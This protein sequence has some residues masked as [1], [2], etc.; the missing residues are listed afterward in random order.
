MTNIQKA[1]ALM[2]ALFAFSLFY[3]FT[4]ERQKPSVQSFTKP[5]AMAG[6][7]KLPTETI[8]LPNGIKAVKPEAAKRIGVVVAPYQHVTATA[9]LPKS[10][11]G[12]DVVSVTDDDGDT[13]MLAKEKPPAL[14]SIEHSGRVGVGAGADIREGK[15]AKVFAEYSPVM[16]F[17]VTVGVEGQ[18]SF[19]PNDVRS[20][21]SLYGGVILFKSF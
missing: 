2:A 13:V 15:S 4:L 16:L 17:G 3:Y 7:V 11:G 5:T 10:K 6:A 12:Y 20:P 18:V 21:V 8:A 19:H 9:S 14:F 1:G